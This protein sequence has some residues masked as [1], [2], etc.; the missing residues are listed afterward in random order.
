[1]ERL[2]LAGYKADVFVCAYPLPGINEV[3]RQNEDGSYTILISEALQKV[4]QLEALNHAIRHIMN[5][6]WSGG[7]VNEI[8]RER[9]AEE[10]QGRQI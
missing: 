10:T 5:E 1:M 7:D 6:D 9:H 4:K 3:V 2:Y 8:E